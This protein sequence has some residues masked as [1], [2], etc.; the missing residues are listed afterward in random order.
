MVEHHGTALPAWLIGTGKARNGFDP[1]VL[2]AAIA[3]ARGK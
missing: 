1:A 3:K 2:R